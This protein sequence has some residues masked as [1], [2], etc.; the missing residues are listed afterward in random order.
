LYNTKNHKESSDLHVFDLKIVWNTTDGIIEP[1]NDLG[2]RDLKDHLVPALSH[3]QGCLPLHPIAQTPS[4][5]DLEVLRHCAV[6]IFQYHISHL[7]CFFISLSAISI[8]L[9]SLTLH[10]LTK[11]CLDMSNM[12]LNTLRNKRRGDRRGNRQH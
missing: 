5:H 9:K 12:A 4:Q 2:W 8:S 10:S 7:V 11:R 3:E 6:Q 1:Q